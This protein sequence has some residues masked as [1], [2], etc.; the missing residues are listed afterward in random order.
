MPGITTGCS[1][2]ASPFQSILDNRQDGASAL[3]EQYL[4]RAR[5]LPR[6]SIIAGLEAC[7]TSF[8]LM[9]VWTYAL[10]QLQTS[11]ANLEEIGQ[12]MVRQTE[13]TSNL[14][15]EALADYRSLLTLS[16]SS[17]VRRTVVSSGKG[18]HELFCAVS[19]PGGEGRL[20]ATTLQKQGITTRLI[21]DQSIPEHLPQV[22]AIILG[23]DQYDSTAF[24]NK[25]GSLD[26]VLRAHDHGL[27]VLVIAEPFK[28]VQSLPAQSP[29]L[30]SIKIME[31][32]QPI[33][34]IMFEWVPWQTHTKLISGG[35]DRIPGC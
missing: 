26:L 16:N 9:A 11:R 30:A 24:I 25:V 13:A 20:L 34:R 32:G 4:E 18:A 17:L 5:D 8:P 2:P 3:F 12:G 23:A 6:E 22:N 35:E 1:D 15:V 31:R 29:E 7:Q 19:Q 10:E 14:A 27:P 33:H 21:G 28:Q